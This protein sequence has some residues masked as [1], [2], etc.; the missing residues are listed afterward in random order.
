VRYKTVVFLHANPRILKIKIDLLDV[1]SSYN[2]LKYTVQRGRMC[3]KGQGAIFQGS[4][5]LLTTIVNMKDSR[6]YHV[7]NCIRAGERVSPCVFQKISNQFGWECIRLTK[8]QM[9]LADRS[10]NVVRT[11]MAGAAA[12]LG[13]IYYL[14]KHFDE[15]HTQCMKLV[16]PCA[17][18]ANQ[19]KVLEWALTKNLKVTLGACKNAVRGAK[20]ARCKH[21]DV[22]KTIQI[23]SSGC[24]KNKATIAEVYALALECGLVAVARALRSQ[25]NDFTGCGSMAI[26]AA[27][28]SGCLASAKHAL[29]HH[30]D[31][32]I[33]SQALHMLMMRSVRDEDER[34]IR[35]V[36]KHG[37]I[38]E[39]SK[40]DCGKTIISTFR[41]TRVEYAMK[42]MDILEIHLCKEHMILAAGANNHYAMMAMHRR[43]QPVTVQSMIAAASRL[44]VKPIK[45][46][47]SIGCSWDSRVYT[48][49]AEAPSTFGQSDWGR[50]KHAIAR[51]RFLK[52]LEK[53]G[54][55][56][57]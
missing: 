36:S 15:A 11:A 39:S 21:T 33:G 17:S 46:A 38:Q 48:A 43:G 1:T 53:S 25:V 56:R 50:R 7:L 54:C 16:V 12:R 9:A 13:K 28:R 30:G 14:D 22:I 49:A 5:K 41:G 26:E 34:V 27:M 44:H 8:G 4:G 2:L 57:A 42:L 24:R 37:S 40:V 3:I 23:I 45:Y 52:W 18:Y 20:A 6:D 35:Y 51:E 19:H 31:V 10:R 32:W 55:P 29:L 47:L